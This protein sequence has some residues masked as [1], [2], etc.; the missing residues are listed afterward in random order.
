MT[1]HAAVSALAA[2]CPRSR[3]LTL[4]E[5]LVA[6]FILSIGLLGLAGLQT[7]SLKFNTSAYYRTQAT[8]LAY[9]LADRMRANRA[10]AFAD[11]YTVALASPAPD[12]AAPNAAGTVPQQ[13][14]SVWRMALACRLPL[15]NGS[16]ARNGNDFTFTIQ[17]DDS[18]G[19]EDPMQFQFTT[20]L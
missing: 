9:G 14:I 13:D 6:L 4:V 11:D 5:I 10:A 12:C 16:V 18:H 19:K 7:A 2:A 8:A 17:W 20:A 1:A 3:G 15:G